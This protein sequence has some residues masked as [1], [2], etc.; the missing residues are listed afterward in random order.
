MQVDKTRKTARFSL[1]KITGGKLLYTVLE[2]R[3]T[4]I[5]LLFFLK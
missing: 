3:A 2:G 5:F 4:T 1:Q